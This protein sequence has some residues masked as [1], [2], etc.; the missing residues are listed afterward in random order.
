MRVD[1]LFLLPASFTIVSLVTMNIATTYRTL[2]DALDAAPSDRLFVLEWH[3]VDDHRT[4]TFGDFR[5][6]AR[7]HACFLKQQGL[8]CG[9][10]VVFVMPQG[11]ALMAAFVGSMSLGALL[12]IL[13]YPNKKWMQ[14]SIVPVLEE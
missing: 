8:R 6:R 4:V 12:T 5:R 9:D 3:D 10:R 1:D 14:Q 11:I 7:Q 13:A 2:L